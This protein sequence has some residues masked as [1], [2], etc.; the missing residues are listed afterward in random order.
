VFVGYIIARSVR[1]SM[2]VCPQHD[3]LFPELT[4]EEHLQLF[5]ALKGVRNKEVLAP[6]SP[7]R[8]TA[9][10][11]APLLNQPLD[12]FQGSPVAGTEAFCAFGRD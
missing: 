11:R 2:G 12:V 10:K 8:L 5:A 7:R 9:H 1:D 6:L 3:V 4:V